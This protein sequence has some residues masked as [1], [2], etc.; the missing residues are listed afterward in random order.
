MPVERFGIAFLRQRLLTEALHSIQNV[1]HQP[2]AD[3]DLVFLK[4]FAVFGQHRFHR[5]RPT[6]LAEHKPLLASD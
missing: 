3:L 6:V 5:G 2:R 4:Q 1:L